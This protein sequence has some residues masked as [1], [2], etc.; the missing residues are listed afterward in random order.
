MSVE[1][2]IRASTALAAAGL[3]AVIVFQVFSG[4]DYRAREQAGLEPGY[5]PA[6]TVV[7]TGAGLVLLI[8]GLVALAVTGVVAL[9]RNKAG[10]RRRP[11]GQ[12][13]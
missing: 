12:P 1:Q 5:A 6:W 2:S 13:A 9:V 11:P 3:L 10:G 4:L 8:V 7:G